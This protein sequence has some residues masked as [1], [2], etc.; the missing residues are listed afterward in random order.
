MIERCQTCGLALPPGSPCPNYWC[1]RDDRGWEAAWA[2]GEHRGWLRHA[3]ARLKYRGEQRWVG[4]L[5][6]LLAGYLLDHAPSFDDVDLLVGVPFHAGPSRP[7]DHV[8]VLLDAVA[9]VVGDLWPVA[10]P[11]A[12]L[13][14]RAE[15]RPLVTAPSAA[16]RRLRA[17][18]EVRTAIV[19][20]DRAALGGARV[21]AVDDVLTDGSTLREVAL[22]L[23]RAGAVAVSGLVLARQPVTGAAPMPW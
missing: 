14:K 6:S 5:A 1:R 23:R 3:I 7:V 8:G 2:V 20:T 4:P 17:A 11:G 19:V 16:A 10:G 22:A 21:L 9:R 15:T 12:V 18:G 13:A